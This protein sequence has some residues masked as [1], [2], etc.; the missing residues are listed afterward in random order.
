[1]EGSATEVALAVD[2]VVVAASVLG[3]LEV[4]L[5]DEVVD[6]PLRRSFGDA[7][8]FGDVAGAGIGVSSDA[9]QHM[10]VIAQKD[11][12][13]LAPGWLCHRD[14]PIAFSL[15]GIYNHEADFVC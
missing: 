10:S 4:S 15:S 5:G 13:S 11:P 2:V 14:S 6:D 7:H 12:C 1:V 3:S 9:E 8:L